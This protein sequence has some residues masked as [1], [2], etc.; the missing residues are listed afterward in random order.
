MGELEHIKS[1]CRVVVRT[2][3]ISVTTEERVRQSRSACAF[4]QTQPWFCGAASLMAYVPMDDEPDI[5]PLIAAALARGVAVALPSVDWDAKTLTPQWIDRWPCP[6]R[7]DRHGVQVPAEPVSGPESDSQA[8]EQ[9]PQVV[10]VPGVAFDD[11]C[12]R[13]G[14]GGGFYDRYIAHRRQA[15]AGG[16]K[17]VFAAGIALE[18]HMLDAVPV[19]P[20]DERLDGVVCPTRVVVASDTSLG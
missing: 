11:R 2:R 10:L 19:G 16:V 1:A 3:L 4:I 5:T 14:R 9:H 7:A 17:R 8:G 13:L 18:A 6:L 12:R 15:A 20:L